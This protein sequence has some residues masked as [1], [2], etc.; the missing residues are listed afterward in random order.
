MRRAASDPA[1]YESNGMD[2]DD[3][4]ALQALELQPGEEVVL[5]GLSDEE[6]ASDVDVRNATDSPTGF[7]S[8]T[9]PMSPMFPKSLPSA[10]LFTSAAAKQSL[11][12]R[13]Q[14]SNALADSSA[15][16]TFG[17]Y[18]TSE[19]ESSE[20]TAVGG[21]L[22]LPSFPPYLPNILFSDTEDSP[23]NCCTPEYSPQQHFRTVSR[24]PPSLHL[25][26]QTQFAQGHVAELQ[27]P[28][29][30]PA[31]SGGCVAVAALSGPDLDRLADENTRLLME[32]MM[33]KQQCLAVASA[34]QV[35]ASAAAMADQKSPSDEHFTQA[36]Q[37]RSFAQMVLLAAANP[38]ELPM[39]CGAPLPG[40][41]SQCVW[42]PAP[43]GAGMVMPMPMPMPPLGMVPP[44]QQPQFAIPAPLTTTLQTHG[45]V[46]GVPCGVDKAR[47]VG[48]Q[49]ADTASFGK[50][51]T[52][53]A[54]TRVQSV[55]GSEPVSG[56]S[57]SGP[58]TVMLRNL[59][60]QYTR[61]MILHLINTEGFAG[62]Y[63]FINLPI[64]FQSKS[65]LG[66]AFVNLVSHEAANRFRMTF[67][68]FSN[69][70]IPSRKVCGVTWS[71]PHQGLEAHVDRYRNSP[72]MH[73][74]VPDMYKPAIFKDGQRIEFPAPTQKL[75]APRTRTFPGKGG[76]KMMDNQDNSEV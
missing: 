4:Q 67:D 70:I 36:M 55:S 20:A 52:D 57:T 64:D 39:P 49:H 51:S 75:R 10:K 46:I 72:V 45:A 76:G 7:M 61:G 74:S 71:G 1:M 14:E 5:T 16:G 15:A 37:L 42:M 50:T 12:L 66:Y 41:P 9:S 38:P 32:N 59:P 40:L 43:G 54:K 56:N 34:A 65:S 23:Q 35:A 53:A 68:G 21:L 73:E 63:D 6:T 25:P 60:N 28:T 44:P 62:L 22:L 27:Q 33:L 24:D 69:W 29:Q 48:R 2:G 8:P 30:H 31:V 13:A 17:G 3:D 11:A 19:G 47:P 26:P 58:T 18:G